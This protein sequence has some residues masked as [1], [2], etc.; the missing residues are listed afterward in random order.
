MP[1]SIAEERK[2]GIAVSPS[3]HYEVTLVCDAS[4]NFS[5]VPVI[6]EPGYLVAIDTIPDE[7]TPPADGYQL[8]LLNS[9]GVDLLAGGG[10][11]RSATVPQRLIGKPSI[12]RDAVYPRILAAGS[13]ATVKIVM[14]LQGT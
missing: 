4:G 13:G 11:D 9:Y 10:V 12:V 2:R 6:V 7:I 14:S 1:G 3:Y 8:E 5:D